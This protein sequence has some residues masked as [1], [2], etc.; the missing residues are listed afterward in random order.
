MAGERIKQER[1]AAWRNQE[2]TASLQ[3][4]IDIALGDDCPRANQ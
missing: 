3:R 1:R 2:I 4:R